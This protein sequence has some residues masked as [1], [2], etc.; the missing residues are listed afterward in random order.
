MVRRLMII[1][2]AAALAG[3]AV[4]GGAYWQA[5]RNQLVRYGAIGIP[6]LFGFALC[7]RADHPFCKV[8]RGSRLRSGSA[9]LKAF[10]QACASEPAARFIPP[11][12]DPMWPQAAQE[13]F[14]T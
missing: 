2:F 11:G 8:T 10:A 4:M 13:I 5:C 12:A 9:G 3:F 14:A 1:A 6:A 7:L